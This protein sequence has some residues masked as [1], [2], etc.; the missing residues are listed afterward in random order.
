MKKAKEKSPL[1][2]GIKDITAR[3]EI[4]EKD[5]Y[6]FLELGLPVTRINNR[7]FGHYRNIDR[8]FRRVTTDDSKDS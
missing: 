5:F 8:F 3:F 7:W 1:L 4:S 2:K 6:T